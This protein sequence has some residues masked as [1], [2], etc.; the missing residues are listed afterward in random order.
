MILLA[1]LLLYCCVG[2]Y[3][4]VAQLTCT[5]LQNNIIYCL[6]PHSI[7]PPTAEPQRGRKPDCYTAVL[8]V[9]WDIN[10]SRYKRRESLCCSSPL[11][12]HRTALVRWPSR[13]GGSVSIWHF[14]QRGRTNMMKYDWSLTGLQSLLLYCAR[15][16]LSDHLGL[17]THYREYL[18]HKMR[19]WHC[20]FHS[21][22]FLASGQVMWCTCAPVVASSGFLSSLMRR[23]RGNLR[24]MP[25][26]GS[27]WGQTVTVSIQ[28]TANDAWGHLSFVTCT[29]TNSSLCS[30]N[31][32]S[33]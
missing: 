30:I 1:C 33:C 23:K 26:S 29:V 13:R 21:L 6:L 18:M 11:N 19:I 3:S 16:T 10:Q 27:T 9:Q 31:V 32:L 20:W 7:F 15:P 12:F 4:G 22:C 24:E 17:R 14:R 2:V 5:S 25:F 28:C 8:T